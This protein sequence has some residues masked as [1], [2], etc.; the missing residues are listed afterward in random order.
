M[1][2]VNNL[3]LAYSGMSPIEALTLVM[4]TLPPYP[5]GDDVL[6]VM[7]KYYHDEAVRFL[8]ALQAHAPG[9]FVDALF[10]ELAQRK[11]SVF[12]VVG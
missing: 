12:R 9:G 11:A 5:G 7:R 6:Q 4:E 10:G 8:D 1:R 2:Y 3:P